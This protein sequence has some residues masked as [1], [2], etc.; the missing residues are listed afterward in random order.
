VEE[1]T[2]EVTYSL[3]A[4]APGLEINIE[5]DWHELGTADIGIPTLRMQ[6]PLGM[7]NMTGRYE[8]PFG[9]I[10]RQPLANQEVPSQRW[11]DVVGK[12]GNNSAGCTLL[13]DCKYGYS[14]DD[15]MLRA[16]LIRSSYD[17]DPLPEHGKQEMKFAILPHNGKVTVAELVRGGTGFNQ[18]LQ[19]VSTDVH[20]GQFP[21][22]GND[23]ISCNPTNVLVTNIKKA[24]DEDAVI[25][26]LQETAGKAT[27]VKVELDGQ[28]FGDVIGVEEV[29]LLERPIDNSTAKV[30]PKGFD[31]KIP[32]NAIA[33]VK[34]GLAE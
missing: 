33:S 9:S 20:Q 16:T 26:R 7:T 11:V 32:A 22:T 18:P 10:Q 25:F 29:D 6:F 23:C 28:L 34:L 19:I 3:K 5:A 30:T 21:A 1:S 17:P 12:I 27:Q 31:V 15:T 2:I 24:E 4:G 14:L 13:N 8:T